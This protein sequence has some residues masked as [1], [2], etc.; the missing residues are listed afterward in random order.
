MR[1]LLVLI[2]LHAVWTMMDAQRERGHF[3]GIRSV[4]SS[5]KGLA[6]ML[7]GGL[8]CACLLFRSKDTLMYHGL[9]GVRAYFADKVTL[10]DHTHSQSRP[11]RRHAQSNALCDP[12]PLASPPCTAALSHPQETRHRLILTSFPLSVAGDRGCR[13][14][15]GAC[16]V[17]GYWICADG[18]LLG[19]V[20]GRTASQDGASGTVGG[21]LRGARGDDRGSAELL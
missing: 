10:T 3:N 2:G 6:G 1:C 19:V 17:R 9:A 13:C 14:G 15:D 16:C 4:T 5:I 21:I 8:C 12:K 7:L 11:L 18:D 20:L